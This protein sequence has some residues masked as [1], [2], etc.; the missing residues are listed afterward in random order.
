[1]VKS[2]KRR[3]EAKELYWRKALSRFFDSG[4]TQTAFCEREGI[5]ANNFC[6][7]KRELAVRDADKTSSA[8]NEPKIT[9]WRKLVARYK[10]SGLSKDEFCKRE[11]LKEAQF[12]WWR[13][14]IA[15][16]DEQTQE[17]LTR[18]PEVIPNAFVPVTI[19]DRDASPNVIA[20]IDMRTGSIRVFE[21]TNADA[22]VA[23]LRAF[24]EFIG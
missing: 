6:W 24:K 15:K 17:V 21:T 7:W 9:F 4:L 5:N 2:T 8:G 20:Q 13:A 10:S 22:L 19:G 18:S 12:R 11:G 16:R 1:M 14:E 3:N 23:I